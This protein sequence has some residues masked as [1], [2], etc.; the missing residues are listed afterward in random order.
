MPAASAIFARS[1]STIFSPRATARLRVERAHGK[2]I[3]TS[4]DGFEPVEPRIACTM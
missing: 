4:F 1:E 2:P 3:V